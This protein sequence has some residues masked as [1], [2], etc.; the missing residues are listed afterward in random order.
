MPSLRTFN[1]DTSLTV[2]P[3]WDNVTGLG[4]PNS[5]WLIAISP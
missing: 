2:G 3:G 5:G 1:H 4:T